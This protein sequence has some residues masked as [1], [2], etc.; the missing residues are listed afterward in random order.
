MGVGH[1][2]QR[3]LPD[4]GAVQL[5]AAVAIG[6]LRTLAFS[7]HALHLHQQRETRIL[8]ECRA[9]EEAH[10]DAEARKLLEDQHL[11]GVGAREPIGTQAEHTVQDPGLGGVAQA[12]ERRAVKPRAGV[13]IVD[14]LLDDFIPVGPCRCS[15]RLKLRADGAALL[16]ALG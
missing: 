11:A 13:A 1:L 15:Q 9:F 2:P 10:G 6:D 12:I 3:D 14:E 5:A 8:A 7:D 16:L 4:A